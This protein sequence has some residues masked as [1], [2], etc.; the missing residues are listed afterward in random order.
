MTEEASTGLASAG[1]RGGSAGYRYCSSH[2]RKKPTPRRHSDTDKC[3]RD[4]ARSDMFTGTT[5]N[6]NWGYGKVNALAAVERAIR[7]AKTQ[8]YDFDGDG[9]SD[10][11]VFRSSDTTW[12]LDRSTDG[13]AAI[14]FGLG[15]DTLAPADYD[16]DGKT[17]VAVWRASE[18]NF[19]IYNSSDSSFVLRILVW[20]EML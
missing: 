14:P 8:S 1:K 2:A 4:S 9:R 15:T 17:D 16:G 7:S 12:Y 6:P 13:F 5:P 3:C 20:P 18:G 19:Y 10:R 11:S